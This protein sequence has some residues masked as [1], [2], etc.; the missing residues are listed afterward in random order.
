MER[1]FGKAKREV[2]ATGRGRASVGMLKMRDVARAANVSVTTVSVALSGAPNSGISEVTRRRV[3]AVAKALGYVP[4]H[5]AQSLRTRRT[6][7]LGIIA[8]RVASTPFAGAVLSGA[9]EA[10]W[11]YG[12]LLLIIETDGRA[13]VGESAAQTLLSR[14]VD[15]IIVAS[16]YHH[17]IEVPRAL[18]G[19]DPLLV[20][21]FS[22]D[23]DY[24]SI[25]PDE[26]GGG[27]LATRRLLKRERSP[28]GFINVSKEKP[29]ATGRLAGYKRALKEAHVPFDRRLAVFGND[30]SAEEGYR[31]TQALLGIEPELHLLFVGTDR[32]AMGAYDALRERSLKI[33]S[34]IGVLGFDNQEIIAAH[35]RP[36]LSTVGLPHYEMGVR[37]V[38][39]LLEPQRNS[40]PTAGRELTPCVY[41]ER[42]SV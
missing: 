21:C 3:K 13:D 35:L 6:N 2:A 5:T 12:C 4:D 24:P 11:K 42:E 18:R 41:V 26:V 23:G 33:P 31:L 28:V 29:A 22:K 14:R 15:H 8:D 37:A 32:M 27:Y 30:E 10:A 1:S 40:E 17:A 19:R 16:D 9:Q 38:N 36:P 34:D 25:V 7:T 39:R 20:N